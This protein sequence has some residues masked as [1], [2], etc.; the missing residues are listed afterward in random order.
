MTQDILLDVGDDA[1]RLAVL[2]DG[3][4]VG[5]FTERDAAHGQMGSIYRGKVTQVLPGMQAAFVEIG[6]PYA[7][8]LHAR[9]A[10]ALC[11]DA[12]GD[13]VLM[14]GNVPRIENLVKAGQELT[15]Q[16]AR[17]AAGDKGPRLTTRW[18]LPGHS[19][20]LLPGC[21]AVGVS[22]RIREPEKREAFLALALDNLPPTAGVVIR[23]AAESTPIEQIAAEIRRLDAVRA[24]IESAERRGSVPR[25]LHAENGL[26]DRIVREFRNAGTNRITVNQADWYERL[27]AAFVAVDPTWALKV[28]HYAGE[29]GLFALHGVESDLERALSRKVWLKSGGW[30]MFDYTE[31]MTVVDV[32]SG[33]YT[34]KTDFQA[35][36]ELVNREA[37]DVLIRQ[38]RLRNLGGIIVV[39]FIDMTSQDSRKELVDLLR[40]HFR[41]A[42]GARTTVVGMTSLGLVEM[43]RKKV[44]QPLHVLLKARNGKA[45]ELAEAVDPVIPDPLENPALPSDAPLQAKDRFQDDTASEVLDKKESLA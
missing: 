17:E 44:S 29:F 34:G 33:K 35:T 11:Y 43:T 14:K 10:H 31:A 39:D 40:D 6:L 32:N 42:D 30:L 19:A 28:R 20:M 23:T 21:R 2:E 8:Y 5:Y 18:T 12:N 25:L 45:A 36:A 9:D 27:R 13:P 4:T 7:G 38:I 37:V 41:E 24:S 1:I 16:I 22:K 3:E 26:Y 15:V